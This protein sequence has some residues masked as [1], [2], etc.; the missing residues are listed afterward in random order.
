[1]TSAA[2]LSLRSTTICKCTQGGYVSIG[3]SKLF[4]PLSRHF[5][6]PTF[7]YM[8]LVPTHL[9]F[10]FVFALFQLVIASWLP[11]PQHA[12][13]HAMMFIDNEHPLFHRHTTRLA[14]AQSPHVNRIDLQTLNIC[15]G[16]FGGS[17]WQNSNTIYG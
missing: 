14:I 9:W 4:P 5:K 10:G 16:R 15:S 11:N 13:S 3:A 7:S 1:M 6:L 12:T 2:L 8:Y 17:W